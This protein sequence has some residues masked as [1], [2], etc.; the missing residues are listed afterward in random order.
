MCVR[1]SVHV[2]VL[3]LVSFH[4][5]WAS[6]SLFVGLDI[7]KIYYIAPTSF[8]CFGSCAYTSLNSKS[9]SNSN[10]KR[11]REKEE[12]NHHRK[13]LSISQNQATHHPQPTVQWAFWPFAKCN[14][15]HLRKCAT[16]R[17][18]QFLISAPPKSC[19][20]RQRRQ[21]QR[22]SQRQRQRQRHRHWRWRW[23]AKMPKC[24]DL[25][26]KHRHWWPCHDFTSVS[27]GSCSGRGRVGWQGVVVG[28]GWCGWRG[29]CF[30]AFLHFLLISLAAIQ[31]CL[32]SRVHWPATKCTRPQ[33]L[34]T[35]TR[36]TQPPNHP[37]SQPPRQTINRPTLRNIQ[38]SELKDQNVNGNKEVSVATHKN[39]L[40]I[41]LL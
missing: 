24:R 11:E 25:K 30:A 23:Q 15:L 6:H 35:S 20:R 34:K 39:S 2:W 22:Q 26:G 29:C 8:A 10:K 33:T 1:E 14:F 40:Q 7:F 16:F 13:H 18:P 28:Y 21:R 31:F 32:C 38:K 27:A 5:Q 36:I 19:H 9:N 37:I 17:G 3:L 4:V 12:E 41:K